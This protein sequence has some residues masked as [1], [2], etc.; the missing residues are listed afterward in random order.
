[1][2]R[3][4]VPFHSHPQTEAQTRMDSLSISGRK[5]REGRTLFHHWY[6]QPKEHSLHMN[7]KS[8]RG[9]ARRRHNNVSNEYY[10]SSA[11]GATARPFQARGDTNK[12]Y[13]PPRLAP[14]EDRD[15]TTAHWAHEKVLRPGVLPRRLQAEKR[16]RN[17]DSG[18]KRVQ[19][20]H[21]EDLLL[22]QA[23]RGTNQIPIRG[24]L[25]G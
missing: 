11:I 16:T 4:K 20:I 21:A 14:K 25:I 12:F 17:T 23:S 15:K 18:G 7:F 6:G 5:A 10:G 3:V 13:I 19:S 1:M 2:N 8:L 24:R 22:I 9:N